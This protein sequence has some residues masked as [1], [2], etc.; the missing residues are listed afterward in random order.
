MRLSCTPEQVCR[1]H[2]ELHPRWGD[3]SGA[4]TWIRRQSEKSMRNASPSPEYPLR[5]E[6]AVPWRRL[7][8]TCIQVQHAP[9]AAMGYMW[10]NDAVMPPHVTRC[11]HSSSHDFAPLHSS[12]LAA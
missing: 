9:H 7:D 5:R 1:Q 8:P 12:P 11:C 10:Q 6:F 4:K 2:V 3:T